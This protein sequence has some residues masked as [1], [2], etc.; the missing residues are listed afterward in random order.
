M[1]QNERI[2]RGKCAGLLGIERSTL[3]RYLDNYPELVD[4]RGL[5][6][7][8][9]VRKHRA[10]NPG[11]AQASESAPK[12]PKSPASI[13]SRQ[14]S[15]HRLEEVKVWQ[16]ELEWAKQVGQVVDPTEMLDQV[17]E[18][19]VALRDKFMA[20]DP[21][22]CER[23]A[24]ETDPRAVMTLL[25]EANRAQLE[26]FAATMKRVVSDASIVRANVVA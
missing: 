11:V 21:V 8:E 15:K 6:E 17:S 24:G 19:A 20:P 25:R 2:K 3:N 23:I 26:E 14:G 16:T 12:E 9:E 1:Q 22:L 10:D 18:A 5:V 13:V 7:L 4:E